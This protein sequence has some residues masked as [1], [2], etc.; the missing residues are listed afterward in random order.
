MSLRPTR[1]ALAA[2]L[3]LVAPLASAAAQG[4]PAPSP[5][6]APPGFQVPKDMTPYFLGLLVK[7]P[8]FTGA[9]T[10]EEMEIMKQHLAYLRTQLEKGVY[11]VAGPATDAG[12]ALGM[13]LVRATNADEARRII[14][15]DP[16]V[17]AGRFALELQAVMLPNM[18]AVKVR[19]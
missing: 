11:V 15:A 8:K 1:L 4:T 5:L 2:I 17:Q 6:Q 12:R 10:P 7:G 3:A 16:A 13:M 19:Y 14:T 9:N 18:D